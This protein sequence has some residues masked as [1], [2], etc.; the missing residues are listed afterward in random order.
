MQARTMPILWLAQD[1]EYGRDLINI[2]YMNEL[3]FNE[4]IENRV[5]DPTNFVIQELIS[6][7]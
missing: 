4:F 6:E 1:L 2:Y 5:Y 3:S 7:S